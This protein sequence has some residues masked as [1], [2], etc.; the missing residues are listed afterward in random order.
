MH[1]NS[2]DCILNFVFSNFR[3][4]FCVCLV[5]LDHP[6]ANQIHRLSTRKDEDV[7]VSLICAVADSLDKLNK[8]HRIVSQKR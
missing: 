3:S 2:S 4:Q 6:P 8:I 7:C 5:G 1:A